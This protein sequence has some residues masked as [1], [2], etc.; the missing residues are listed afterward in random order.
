MSNMPKYVLAI[1]HLT[2]YKD[3]FS[4]YALKSNTKAFAL[5]EAALRATKAE[6][7][8]CWLLLIRSG[9]D[10]KEYDKVIRFYPNDS[11]KHAYDR[12]GG[13]DLT[14]DEDLNGN[15]WGTVGPLIYVN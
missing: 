14:T 12:P 3:A 1:D 13:F 8:Y 9:K 10:S 7:V 6:K 4:Y 15:H 11:A 2:E 5:A